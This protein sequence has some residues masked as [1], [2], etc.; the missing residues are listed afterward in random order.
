MTGPKT[1]GRSFLHVIGD[2]L[3]QSD[4]A[5]AYDRESSGTTVFT[6]FAH[7]HDNGF[8]SMT[9][10]EVEALLKVAILFLAA[11]KGLVNFHDALEHGIV[12]LAGF[13]QAL[14]NEPCGL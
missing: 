4:T 5:I 13:S 1:G 7:T 8:S 9:G 12:A 10:T 3:F 2:R 14:E 11:N 6:A